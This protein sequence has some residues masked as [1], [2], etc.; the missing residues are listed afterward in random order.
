[1]RG[2]AEEAKINSEATFSDGILHMDAPVLVDQQK[3][4]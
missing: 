2:T 1:M 3:I 4:T